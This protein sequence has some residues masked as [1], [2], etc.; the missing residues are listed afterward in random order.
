[1]I[2][3]LAMYMILASTFTLGK[4]AL[5]YV[6]PVFFIASRMI[7]SGLLLL[8]YVRFFRRSSWRLS[9]QDWALFALII[10]FHIYFSFVC[11]FVAMKTMDS[12]KACLLYGLSPFLTALFTFFFF[13]ECLSY[14]KKI[15]LAIGLLGFVP[16]LMSSAPQE[17]ATF[18]YLSQADMYMLWSVVSSVIGWIVMKRLVV[19]GYS[20]IMVNGIGMLAGGILALITAGIAEAEW[21]FSAPWLGL[22]TA[23]DMFVIYTG[24]T[25]V[26]ANIV[27]YNMYGFLLKRYSTTFISF[28]GF[29]CP[30]FAALYGWLFLGEVITS[31]F[32]VSMVIITAGLYVFYKEE[33]KEQEIA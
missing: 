7:V 29:T 19:R 24:L 16:V 3:I 13:K 5:M 9:P 23:F 1:M 6:K 30:L 28:A 31:W 26:I 18:F 10:L 17:G 11:E 21:N 25:V 8:G 33:L 27:C 4:A 14:Y 32:F 12:F 22:I 20:P 2:A 15:G